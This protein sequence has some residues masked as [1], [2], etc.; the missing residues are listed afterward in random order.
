MNVMKF[1]VTMTVQHVYSHLIKIN[2][3]SA[4]IFNF[5]VNILDFGLMLD[6]NNSCLLNKLKFCRMLDKRIT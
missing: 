1:V 6:F 5:S 3:V 4:I 2:T